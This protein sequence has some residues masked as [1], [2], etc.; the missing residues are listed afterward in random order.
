MILNPKHFMKT[1]N[2]IFHEEQ[3]QYAILSKQQ[4]ETAAPQMGTKHCSS[5]PARSNK[6]SASP[7][8]CGVGTNCNGQSNKCNARVTSSTKQKR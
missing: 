8:K 6:Q 1:L 4:T 2:S 5:N 7:R 3:V